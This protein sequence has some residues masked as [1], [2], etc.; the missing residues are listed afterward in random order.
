MAVEGIFE[1]AKR[2]TSTLIS[3]SLIGFPLLLISSNYS[4]VLTKL[5][6]LHLRT[7]IAKKNSRVYAGIEHGDLWDGSQT[8]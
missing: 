6:R 1:L 7:Y 8:C 5:D 2:Y 4:I 3:V